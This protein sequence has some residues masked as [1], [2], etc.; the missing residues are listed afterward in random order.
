MDIKLDLFDP[1]EVVTNKRTIYLNPD[2]I[3]YYSKSTDGFTEIILSSG[4]K[5]IV[6]DSPEYI[7]R[8]R[9]H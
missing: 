3:E 1:L 4:T 2:K 8:E 5:L 9:N 6:F 7:N